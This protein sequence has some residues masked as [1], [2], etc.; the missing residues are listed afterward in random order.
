M[1]FDISAKDPFVT[2][3][4]FDG[5]NQQELEDEGVSF[6]PYHNIDGEYLALDTDILKPGQYVL[7]TASGVTK[8]VDHV[9]L[10]ANYDGIPVPSEADPVAEIV[11]EDANEPDPDA[12]VIE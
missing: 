4:L 2:A 10:T 12:V 7:I 5:E 3:I 11:V 6:A 8:V 9:W 1:G